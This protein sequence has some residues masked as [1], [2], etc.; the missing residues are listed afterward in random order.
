VIVG[1]ET[2]PLKQARL[3]YNW[4]AHNIRCVGICAGLG[5]E[6]VVAGMNSVKEIDAVLN[7]TNHPNLV[8]IGFRE[9]HQRAC[10]VDAARV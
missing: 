8:L 3:L 9:V 1:K 2:D 10:L 7:H 5:I 4:V 6:R